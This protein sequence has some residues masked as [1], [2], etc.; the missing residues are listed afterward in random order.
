M[1]LK[2][3]FIES[4]LSKK[5]IGKWNSMIQK[6]RADTNDATYIEVRWTISRTGQ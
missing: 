4:K 5:N 2:I 3:I 1:F 6:Y